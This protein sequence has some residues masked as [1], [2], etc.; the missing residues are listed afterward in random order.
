MTPPHPTPC[1]SCWQ[2][3]LMNRELCLECLSLA[4]QEFLAAI[5]NANIL[6]I[7]LYGGWKSRHGIFLSDSSSLQGT[8]GGIVDMMSQDS[9]LSLADRA[10][11]LAIHL[12]R[13]WNVSDF[14]YLS[15]PLSKKGWGGIFQFY[16]NTP[17]NFMMMIRMAPLSILRSLANH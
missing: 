14:T 13:S 5:T 7:S 11:G 15:L 1:A 12:W 4:E 17:N 16:I 8:W 2:K 9:L 3:S 10:N 6:C